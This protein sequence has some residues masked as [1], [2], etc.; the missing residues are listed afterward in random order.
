MM[1]FASLYVTTASASG[2]G[3]DQ[4]VDAKESEMFI[5][6]RDFFDLYYGM[7]VR[8]VAIP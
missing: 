6:I 2:A 4:K 1:P 7:D 8:L 3:N 5:S